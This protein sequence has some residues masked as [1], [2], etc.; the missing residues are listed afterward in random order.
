MKQKLPQNVSAGHKTLYEIIKK[1]YPN[2][3]IRLE[4][5]VAKLLKRYWIRHKITEE[6]QDQELL[7]K[8]KRLSIDIFDF[9]A[10]IAFEV[11]GDQ[12]YNYNNFFHKN[13]GCL[14][15]QKMND[16]IK[17]LICKETKTRLIIIKSNENLTEEMIREFYK[18]DYSPAL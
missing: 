8:A 1:L 14:D 10:N 18:T 4:Y 2:N 15:K 6:Y 17:K 11:N 5:S 12:H 9:T 3:D 13:L 16:N 7:R